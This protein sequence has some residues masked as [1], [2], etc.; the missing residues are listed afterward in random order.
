MKIVRALYPFILQFVI[1]ICDYTIDKAVSSKI[2]TN[3]HT[4]ISKRQERIDALLN[5]YESLGMADDEK[6]QVLYKEIRELY[7]DDTQLI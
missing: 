7:L 1:V 3:W 5:E 6:F 4:Q 2:E